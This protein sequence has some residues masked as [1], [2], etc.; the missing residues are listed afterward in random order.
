M[1]N[2]PKY[3]EA[4]RSAYNKL[5]VIIRAIIVI[6]AFAIGVA[7]LVFI[8]TPPPFFDL[9]VL[10]LL[11]SLSVLSFQ[12]AWAHTFLTYLTKKL[13]DKAF[14]KKLLAVAGIIFIVFLGLIIYW[15][16]HKQ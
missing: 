8:F 15:I 10:A 6:V 7:G 14:R 4:R 13:A 11:L 16:Q 3:V 1:V 2:I 9:G 5:P 12:F